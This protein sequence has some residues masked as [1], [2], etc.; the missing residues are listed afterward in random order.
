MSLSH[1]LYLEVRSW[2]GGGGGGALFVFDC[3]NF[4]SLAEFCFETL[5]LLGNMDMSP[6][7]WK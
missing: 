1:I 7:D 4:L 3:E 6:G 5:V 2:G